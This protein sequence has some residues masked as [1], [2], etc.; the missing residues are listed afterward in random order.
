MHRVRK[1]EPGLPDTGRRSWSMSS[2][3]SGGQLEPRQT[4]FAQY[5]FSHDEKEQRGL[6]MPS[7][8]VRVG[9]ALKD[10]HAGLDH[11]ALMEKYKL[12][13]TGLKCLFTEMAALGL[14]GPLRVREP[15]T[16]RI[17]IKIREFLRDFRTGLN[18]P[19]LMH[20]YHLSRQALNLLYKRLLDLKAIRADE[21]FGNLPT[22][23]RNG[24]KSDSRQM[25]RYALDF[26]LIAYDMENPCTR[27]I[28]RDINERGVRVD[29]FEAH[30]GEV[31][32]LVVNAEDIFGIEPFRFRSECRW[33]TRGQDIDGT[34]A[35]FKIIAIGHDDLDSLKKLLPLLTMNA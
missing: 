32:S 21:L 22:S 31:V 20:K 33:R 8:E 11:L 1:P 34:S 30:A 26:P 4:R 29:G 13:P 19:M 9:E 35:G 5:A 18:D 14:F 17:R 28:I 7:R 27:G 10:I 2:L 3:M 23:R 15:G 12:S 25:T 16:P 24:N 6:Q